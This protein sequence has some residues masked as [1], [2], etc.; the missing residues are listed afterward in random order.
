MA[1]LPHCITPIIN[2]KS[3]KRLDKMLSGRWDNTGIVRFKY[4]GEFDIMERIHNDCQDDLSYIGNSNIDGSP[5]F[6]YYYNNI[7]L[8][9]I[10]DFKEL[11]LV[12]RKIKLKYYSNKKLT[13]KERSLLS[14][15]RFFMIA[16]DNYEIKGL[17]LSEINEVS[18]NTP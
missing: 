4:Y 15:F 13:K 3:S 14:F 16:Y 17:S 5:V 10:K 8:N 9:T 1:P 12:L 11:N 7:D 18:Y 6:A 2:N